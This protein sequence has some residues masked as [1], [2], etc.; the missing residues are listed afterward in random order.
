MVALVELNVRQ[1]VEAFGYI[2]VIPIEDLYRDDGIDY[3]T[4]RPA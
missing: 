1:P 3:L 2:R 4:K